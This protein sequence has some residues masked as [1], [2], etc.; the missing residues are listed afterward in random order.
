MAATTVQNVV[1]YN[2]VIDVS[3]P[4]L[5]LKPGMTANVKIEIEKAE[6]VT[7]LPN[8]AIRFR[9]ELSDTEI[10]AAFKRAGEERFYSFYRN[11]GNRSQGATQA[12]SQSGYSGNAAT[13]FAGGSRSANGS[14]TNRGEQG[15]NSA[16][17]RGRRTPVW[18]VGEDKL[19]RP[20]I[21][22]LGLTDGVVTQIDEGKLKAGDKVI[23][24]AEVS[25]SRSTSSTTTRAPGFGSPMGG[26][27]RR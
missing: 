23:L 5:R 14:N 26:G 22:K 1:T 21:L 12:R 9:P 8:A 20:V 18:I 15:S 27:I 7:R 24:S 11:Q 13:G 19:L 10:A 6:N 4:D 2:A 25:G 16:A 17:N 3:N